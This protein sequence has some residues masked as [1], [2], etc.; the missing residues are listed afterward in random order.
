MTWFGGG[1][2]GLATLVLWIFCV[3]DVIGSEETLVRNLPKTLWLTL[4]IFVPLIG[5]VAWLIMGRPQKISYRPGTTDYR[6]SRRPVGPED[7]ASF[8]A[9]IEKRRLQKWE[10]ELRTREEEVK[11]REQLP[12]AE[13]Q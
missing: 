10:Q 12:P 11:K 9:E 13:D 4:V 8:Q 6:G 7:G 3:F 2:V 5:S 1:I